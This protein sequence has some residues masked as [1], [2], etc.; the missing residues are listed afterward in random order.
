MRRER[1][2]DEREE[3]R[4]DEEGRD[5]RGEKEWMEE[6]EVTKWNVERGERKKERKTGNSI[7]KERHTKT[8]SP[9]YFFG[10]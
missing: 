6:W 9:H 7:N 5:E 3:G 8:G 4:Y 10:G 1:R 2:E